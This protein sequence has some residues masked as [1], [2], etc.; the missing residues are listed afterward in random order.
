MHWEVLF[1]NIWYYIIKQY[2]YYIITIE[3]TNAKLYKV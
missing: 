2:K 1:S 3:T